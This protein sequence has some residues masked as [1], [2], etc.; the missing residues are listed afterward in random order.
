M[1]IISKEL[2]SIIDITKQLDKN[3][4]KIRQIKYNGPLDF[5]MEPRDNIPQ[6]H[7]DNG[8]EAIPYINTIKRTSF[9][10][11]NKILL[12]NPIFN[13]LVEKIYIGSKECHYQIQQQISSYQEEP[14][15]H[16]LKNNKNRLVDQIDKNN[17]NFIISD[18]NDQNRLISKYSSIKTGA[19]YFR[20]PSRKA[21]FSPEK[22]KI[23]SLPDVLD[24]HSESFDYGLESQ[25]KTKNSIQTPKRISAAFANTK[26]R[27]A[28]L[29]SNKQR[30]LQRTNNIKDDISEQKGKEYS[31]VAFN[32]LKN[33]TQNNFSQSIM[34]GANEV[35]AIK[36]ENLINIKIDA[37][38]SSPNRN[39]SNIS[40]R[41][42]NN[43][44]NYK[45]INKNTLYYNELNIS[46]NNNNKKEIESKAMS[47]NNNP[48]DYFSME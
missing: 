45:G 19:P 24:R 6:S 46:N 25:L 36:F 27:K 18:S 48:L 22:L 16:P 7:N 30:I 12:N 23:N 42:S 37:E 14:S 2:D 47:I 17:S 3:H 1:K 44:K 11:V 15:L 9:P 43:N 13:T 5:K 38:S 4:I 29:N 8:T 26:F 31:D 35:K 28:L 40:Q 32:K 41:L 10:L 21:I 34:L 33:Q 20:T 39:Q